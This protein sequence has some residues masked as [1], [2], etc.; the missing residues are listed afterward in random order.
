MKIRAAHILI[1]TESERESA[2]IRSMNGI[3]EYGIDYVQYITT[4]YTN[5]VWKYQRPYDEWIN[6]KS[7]HFGLYR[8]AQT[9]IYDYFTNDLDAFMIF[10]ADCMRCGDISLE[11]FIDK[12]HQAVRFSI[13]HNTFLFSFGDRYF[14]TVL[15]SPILKR[16]DEYNDFVITDKIIGC[17]CIL[18]IK[19]NRELLLKELLHSN[20]DGLDMWFNSAFYANRYKYNLTLGINDNPITYQ[21]EAESMIDGVVKKTQRMT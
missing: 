2:S 21:Y 16:D 8:S 18:M 15:Q 9:V 5:D 3:S 4:Q 12:V 14:E 1:D 17:H 10:E 19:Q 13:K 11:H 7:A 20:W 6:H